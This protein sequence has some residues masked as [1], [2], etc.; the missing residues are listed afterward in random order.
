M[1]THWRR[2]TL[3]NTSRQSGLEESMNLCLLNEGRSAHSSAWKFHPITTEEKTAPLLTVRP[4]PVHDTLL[5]SQ[6][7]DDLDALDAHIAFLGIPFGAA[8]D[9]FA[10]SSEQSQG[11]DAIRRATDRIVR[12]LDHYDF[13]LGGTLLDGQPVRMA[14]CGNVAGHPSDPRIHQNNA[15][16]AVRKILKAGAMPIVLGG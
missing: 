4:A 9:Q 15:E 7:C 1:H 11:P 10:V 12:G 14:D 8:Y 6:A 2:A 3:A 13:D 5:F 16:Q